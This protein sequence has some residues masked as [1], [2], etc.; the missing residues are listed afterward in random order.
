MANLNSLPIDTPYNHP[1]YELIDTSQVNKVFTPD[2]KPAAFTIGLH[3]TL[4]R[5]GDVEFLAIS[6][7]PDIFSVKGFEEITELLCHEM[8]DLFIYVVYDQI[9]LDA[10]IKA[11]PLELLTQ[12]QEKHHAYYKETYLW[13]TPNTKLTL[14]KGKNSARIQAI[15]NWSTRL[16][17][18]GAFRRAKIKYDVSDPIGIANGLKVLGSDIQKKVGIFLGDRWGDISNPSIL[19]RHVLKQDLNTVDI[20]SIPEEALHLAYDSLHAPWI[21]IMAQGYFKN[22]FDYDLNSAYP[23]EIAKLIN[24]DA[25]TGTWVEKTEYV[26]EAEYGYCLAVISM[27]QDPAAASPIKFRKNTGRLFSPYG[28]WTGYITKS[29]IDFVRKWNLGRIEVLNGW[30]FI[31]KIRVHPFR[32]T[33]DR[34]IKIREGARSQDPVLSAMMKSVA[35]RMNGHFLQKYQTLDGDWIAG[36]MFNPIFACEVM[37]RTKL[38]V[39]EMALEAARRGGKVLAATV[40]GLVTTTRLSRQPVHKLV[41]HSPA[42]IVAPLVMWLEDRDAR[43]HILREIFDKPNATR[44]EFGDKKRIT[45]CEAVLLK[46]PDRIGEDTGKAPSIR[47][48]ADVSRLWGEI[49]ITGKDLLNKNYFGAQPPIE[50]VQLGKG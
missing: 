6:G 39:A 14:R 1:F 26:R 45:L 47:V 44:Y 24:C 31:P 5:E 11:L 3:T 37:T 29:E 41:S 2:P 4:T 12:L 7:N 23:T 42:L 17:I 19:T 48:G 30:W 27:D 25:R 21:E 32:R 43:Y 50:Y 38:K 16:T 13:Y 9:T 15:G 8:G 18:K 10:L 20:A 22:A 46:R 33:V 28:T 36:S 49:P 35:A 34:L 40:D